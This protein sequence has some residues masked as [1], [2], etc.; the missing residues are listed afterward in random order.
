[1]TDRWRIS[2]RPVVVH[3]P[4]LDN[5]G[6]LC[7]SD[8]GLCARCRLYPCHRTTEETPCSD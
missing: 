4:H 8:P 2:E 6:V 5:H 7:T 1:M 3:R